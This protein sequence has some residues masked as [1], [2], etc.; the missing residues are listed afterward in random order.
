MFGNCIWIV[1]Q[2]FV[3]GVINFENSCSISCF[4]KKLFLHFDGWVIKPNHF[5]GNKQ[6]NMKTIIYLGTYFRFMKFCITH[7]RVRDHSYITSANDWVGL[8]NGRF[9][10]TYIQYSFCWFRWMGPK[11]SKMCWHNTGSP[12]LTRFWDSEKPRY[13]RSIS[14]LKQ[15]NGTF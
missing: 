4:M 6:M 3:R 5:M 8:E 14:V 10:L 7:F 2:L 11:R 9:L 1:Q 13:R 15:E 12:P